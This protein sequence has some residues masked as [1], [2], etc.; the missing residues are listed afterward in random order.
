M[1]H[2]SLYRDALRHGLRLA[3]KEKMLW[4]LGLFAGLLGQMGILELLSSVGMSSANV[5]LT[6]L[7]MNV[8]FGSVEVSEKNIPLTTDKLFWLVWVGL[9]LLALVVFL[10]YTAVIAQGA[11]IDAVAQS[12]DAKK[13]PNI[14]KAWH[15]GVSHF[16]KLFGIT[17]LRKALFCFLVL[18]ST[19]G[20]VFALGSFSGWR[21]AAGIGIFVVSALLGLLLSFMSIYAAG[22]I[23]V[24]EYPFWRAISA[25]WHLF[26]SHWLV[27]FEVG[28]VLLACN[29]FIVLVLLFAIT[30]LIIPTFLLWFVAIATQSISL[31]LIGFI[32][33]MVLFVFLAI[34]V[35]SVFTVF[36]TSVWTDLFM[37]MHRRGIKSRILHFVR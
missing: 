29:I 1:K 31:F 12:K 26:R 36:T 32:V 13:E 5:S 10:I 28:L 2:P 8:L 35:G 9:A 27:S 17:A 24:E 7:W 23:V 18:V 22:Y 21:I 3:W 25:A 11:I 20:M 34:F 4:P 6:P 16:W 30:V 19:A 14:G 37:H 33:T 15:R